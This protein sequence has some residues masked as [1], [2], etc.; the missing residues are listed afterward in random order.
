MLAGIITMKDS[1]LINRRKFLESTAVT[2]I[3]GAF[4]LPSN[5]AAN[6]APPKTTTSGP[7]LGY[8]LLQ[9]VSETSA[10]VSWALTTPSTGWVEWGPTPDFGKIARNSEFGLNPYETDFLSARLTGLSP[11]TKYYYRTATCPF[12]YKTAYDKTVSE[13]LY[14]ETYS[15]TTSGSRKDEVSFYV[16]NDTHNNTEVIQRHIKEADAFNADM[17]VW[18]GDLCS[19]YMSADTAKKYL[20]NPIDEPYA[21]NRPLVF[22]PGN[23]DRRGSWVRNLKS[24]LTP[25]L[26][27]ESENSSLGY[28]YAFRCGPVA[29]ILL[30][31]GEDKPDWHPAWSRMANFEPYREAQTAW[32]EKALQ[33]PEISSAPFLVACCHIPLHSDKPKVNPGNILDKWATIQWPCAQQWGPLFDKYG[34]QLLISAHLHRFGYSPATSERSWAQIVGGGPELNTNA[35]S[36][37]VKASNDKMMLQC[38]KL[39]DGSELGAW[40]FQPR[41]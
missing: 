30:D 21:S 9:N 36:I 27:T 6:D 18:N 39:S 37:F 35:C 33:R 26:H 8:P 14:S 10:S 23:H 5:V 3:L 31:T 11:N 25:W 7:T 20:A 2:G 4:A 15:F 32:L 19:D 29:M 41:G 34:V 40:E 16:M 13:P 1:R 12:E 24:C 38:K 22:V 17:I 28:N